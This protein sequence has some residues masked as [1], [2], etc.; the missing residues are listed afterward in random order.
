MLGFWLSRIFSFL[1]ILAPPAI[2]VFVIV[3]G[4]FTPGYNQ[5]T[6]TISSLGDQ[7]SHTPQLMNLGFFIY[8]T[9]MIGFAY[10][11]YLHLRHGFKAHLAWF[12]FTLYGI[13]MIL[14]GV[15]QDSPGTA[16]NTE[17]FVHNAVI[18]TSCL[19]MLFGMWAFADSVYKR[20]SWFGFTWFTFIASFLGL[21]LSIIFLVQSQVPLAG[22]FQRLF[23][24]ILLIWIEIVAVWL[25]KLSLK[26]KPGF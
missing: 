14:A 3:A 13:C 23:Y 18:I 2:A 6:D 22:L 11:L 16:M 9:L 8:G 4:H 20:P 19:S 10:A 5:L 1:G 25:F 24:G 17:G 7:A 26:E 15:F 21:I 12:M